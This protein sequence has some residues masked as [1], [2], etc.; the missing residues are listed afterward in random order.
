MGIQ[1]AQKIGRKSTVLITLVGA[2]FGVAL[3]LALYF[4]HTLIPTNWLELALALTLYFF[5]TIMFK[6]AFEKEEE[7]HDKGS[8][9]YGYIMVVSLESVE[10]AA[11]LAALTFIDISGAF[12][13]AAISVSVFVALALASRRLMSR[14]PLAKLRLI[15]GCLLAL[16]ATP[17][18]IYSLGLP[19]PDWLQWIIPRLK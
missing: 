13:G 10:N 4:F 7:E 11:A 8:Y 19:A 6:E 9:K 17:L 14:I 16:T 18:L 2:S 1:A 15:A 12:V 3:F 5:A